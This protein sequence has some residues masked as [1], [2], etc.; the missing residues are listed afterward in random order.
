MAEMTIDQL[1]DFIKSH[2]EP[3]KQF[4]LDLLDE[5]KQR[6]YE[7]KHVRAVMT[8]LKLCYIN[9]L[10]LKIR[11]AQEEIAAMR[12]GDFS[13]ENY[14]T[15]IGRN[16]EIRAWRAQIE[17]YK[18]FFVEPYFARMDLVD[19]KEGYNSYYIGKKG[20]LNLEIVDWRA[21]LARKYY[22]KSQI[23]F[24]INEY[25]YRQILRRALRTKNGKFLDFKNEYL[26]LRDYLTKEEI[27]GRDEEII[28]DPYLKEILRARKEQDEIS[29]IIE[30]I[31]E[32]Q[33]EIITKP[34]RASFV[35]QGCAGSGKTMIML[36]RLSFL[37]YNNE[38][39]KPSDVLVIT[40]SDSFNAFIDELSQVLELE[41]I[42]TRKIDEYFLQLLQSEGVDIAGKIDPAVKE[43]TAYLEYIYSEKFYAD[44]E[45]RLSK[46]YDGILG[47]FLSEECAG[48]VESV[49][50]DLRAQIELFGRL[51]NASVRVRRAVLGEIKEKPEGG[52]YYTKPY[53]ALMNEVTAAEEF[54]TSGLHGERVRSESAF[55][56]LLLSFYRAGTH[57]SHMHARVAAAADEDLQ[58]LYETV[59][60]EIA[61]LRRYKLVRGDKEIETYADRIAHRGELLKEIDAMRGC[62]A[63]IEDG[64]TAFCELFETLCGNDYFVKLGKCGTRIELA[65]LFYRETVRRAKN[66]FGVGKG[67][68]RSDAYSICLILSLLGAQ[69]GPRF[70]LVFIDEGQDISVNEYHLLRRLNPDA[71]FNIYGDL[72]QNITG[73][74]GLTDWS[75]VNAGE[76]YTLEQNYR[77]T[78]Q[79]VEYVARNLGIAM[80]PI[81]FDGPEVAHIGVRGIGG[82]FRDKKGLKAVIVP[83]GEIEHY[84]RKSYNVLSDTGRLSKKKVNL[85][86]VYESKGLEFTCVAVADRNMTRQEKYIAYTRALK[87]LAIVGEGN[88][89][90]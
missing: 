8:L 70:G 5:E 3:D 21:P 71:A 90:D 69:P 52:L 62:V 68:V 54:L 23:V 1:R 38:D 42:K 79:I 57:I 18:G 87:E 39:L 64:F 86:T 53:R 13:A 24:S 36:H 66:R 19:D 88:S 4:Y 41:K 10:K 16:A 40:P 17:S 67:L 7:D 15:I 46:I 82:F 58:R 49:A 12:K 55:Y 75:K 76:Y 78:N 60:K 81:G 31:Q 32:K 65:R 63:Q 9:A 45:K 25:N 29:D 28:F 83:E 35:L 84:R 22:Q 44:A 26:N 77:N 73:Y 61:D 56:G 72:A 47:M 80:Q 50:A 43:P 27:A 51:K 34:E 11:G 48:I 20:D 89:G 74:R 85:M 33:Y 30:T 37:M 6:D 59:V 2:K 14:R